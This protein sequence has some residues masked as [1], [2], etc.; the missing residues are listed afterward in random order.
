MVASTA[1]AINL[2]LKK[3]AKDDLFLLS[4]LEVCESLGSLDDGTM[5]FSEKIVII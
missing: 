5:E 2:V 1:M 4:G 3:I